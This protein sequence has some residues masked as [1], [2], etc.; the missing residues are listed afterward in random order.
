M[1]SARDAIGFPLSLSSRA[2]A[3]GQG[4]DGAEEREAADE[5]WLHLV[6][7]SLEIE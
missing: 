5:L 2:D 3:P 6:V 7:T 4:A 1:A